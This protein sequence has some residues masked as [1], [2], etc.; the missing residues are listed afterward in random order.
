MEGSPTFQAA[1][2][3]ALL[4]SL[5]TPVSAVMQQNLVF[6]IT[7]VFPKLTFAVAIA[8]IP[9]MAPRA[10]AVSSRMCL[11][12][13]MVAMQLWTIPL[14]LARDALSLTQDVTAMFVV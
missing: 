11:A 14:V 13:P 3:T 7:L 6:A 12:K 1:L 5:A 2:V 10:I 4:H 9:G 8:S